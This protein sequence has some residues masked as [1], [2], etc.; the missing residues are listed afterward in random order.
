MKSKDCCMK[1][2][3]TDFYRYQYTLEARGV[4]RTLSNIKHG[5]FYEKGQQLLAV[6][7]FSETLYLRFLTVF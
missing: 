7:Y 2:N 6:D 5:V 4:L 1:K 3:K